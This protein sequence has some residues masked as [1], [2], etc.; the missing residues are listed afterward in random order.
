MNFKYLILITYMFCSISYAQDFEQNSDITDQI[1][2]ELK[3]NKK[4]II[5][6]GNYKIDAVK[7]IKPQ[8]GSIIT[9][10]KDTLLNV[11]P[12]GNSSYKVFDISNLQNVTI[13]GG[14]LIGD[15]YSHLNK[16]GEWG[17]GIDIR[18]S[19]NITISNIAISKMWGDAIYIGTKGKHYN[20]GITLNNLKLNDNRRQGISL[21]SAKKLRAENL[22][23]SNTKGTSPGSGID[24]EPNNADSILEDIVFKNI[25][26]MN[27]RGA[28]FQI[29]LKQ[30]KNTQNLVDIQVINHQDTGSNFGSLIEGIDKNHKG[31]ITFNETNYKKNRITNN[32]F[33]SW[34]NPYFNIEFNQVQNDNIQNNKNQWCH[35]IKQNQNIVFK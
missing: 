29:T 14:Q 12:N 3:K 26:T 16:N 33:D 25:Q 31:K 32:C 15:K 19:Q 21:I 8:N 24:I 27:N 5:P 13:T 6:A 35:S 1:N 11:I 10:S 22:V 17:M 20:Y 9:M 28:G 4:V 7:S 2:S 18:D 30:F 23:I 34:R